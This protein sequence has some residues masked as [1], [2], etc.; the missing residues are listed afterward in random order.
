MDEDVATR[1]RGCD[2][3]AMCRIVPA[4]LVLILGVVTM[5]ALNSYGVIGQQ[6]DPYGS[7]PARS[8]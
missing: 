3:A 7:F 8:A 1:C 4:L 5:C 2:H 6:P